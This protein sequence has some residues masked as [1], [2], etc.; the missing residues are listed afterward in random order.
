MRQIIQEIEQAAYKIIT[1]E[2]VGAV[3]FDSPH[4]CAEYPEDFKPSCRRE[5]LMTS[6][7][8]FIDELFGAAPQFGA[9]LLIAKFPRFYLDVNREIDDIDPEMLDAP[10]D[11]AVNPSS[12]SKVGMGLIRRFALP[13]IAVY[14]HLLTPQQVQTRIENCYIP[15]YSA[16][17]QLIDNAYQ[18]HGHVL[19]IDCHSMKSRGNAMNDDNGAL[20]PDIVVSDR[21]H[22]TSSAEVT[23]YVGELF[24]A[25]GLSVGINDPYKG[26]E[27]IRRYSDVTAKK[28][29]VQ[30][31]LNRGI[32]M[33]EAEF[34]K[35][36]G[37]FEK[38]QASITR[39]IEKLSAYN[40]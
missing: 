18:Q 15:Y 6:L 16:L 4:S 37:D 40:F 32:Y 25:E 13:G 9:P 19:H 14:D 31:E 34:T 26:A 24:R 10:F 22:T 12:K 27:L 21:D 36:S 38:L 30:I 5:D 2:K 7:D 11:G 23:E 39:V 17:G 29:G 28:Y 3:V 8:A 20:R 35:K 1:P 33:N